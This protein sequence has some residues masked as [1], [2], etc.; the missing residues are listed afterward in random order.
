MHDSFMLDKDIKPEN[1]ENVMV[2]S[3][4]MAFFFII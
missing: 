2:I 1:I 3:V 4:W